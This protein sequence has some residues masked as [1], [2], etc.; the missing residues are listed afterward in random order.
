MKT[1]GGVDVQIHVLLTS[2]LVEG[3]WLDSHF[4]HFTREE[5]IGGWVSRRT[6]PDDVERRKSYTYRGSNS[7][8]S[9]V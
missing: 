9:A 3:E 1:Y 2:V 4:G 7:D 5:R 8:P 6:C